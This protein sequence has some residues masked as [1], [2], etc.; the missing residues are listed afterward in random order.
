MEHKGAASAPLLRRLAHSA[1]PVQVLAAGQAMAD[2]L[3]L[4]PAAVR[5]TDLGV[6]SPN[7]I[8]RRIGGQRPIGGID[9]P[10]SQVG[11]D[12]R[13]A[14][15]RAVEHGC[16]QL[17]FVVLPHSLTSLPNLHIHYISSIRNTYHI[18]N[19]RPKDFQLLVERCMGCIMGIGTG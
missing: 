18:I 8:E 5:R 3:E 4:L 19:Q 13:Q 1:Q 15:R 12:H 6:L 9:Q 16:Q 14:H 17:G 10:E 7:R 11:A 2:P